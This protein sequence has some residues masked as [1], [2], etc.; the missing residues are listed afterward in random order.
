MLFL[1]IESL[2]IIHRNQTTSLKSTKET[3][4]ERKNH[5]GQKRKDQMKKR[6]NQDKQRTRS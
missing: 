1:M 4:P 3:T 6:E 5:K 2:W